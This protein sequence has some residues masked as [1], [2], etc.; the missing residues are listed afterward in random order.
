VCHYLHNNKQHLSS[1]TQPTTEFVQLPFNLLFIHRSV[2][3]RA[4]QGHSAD[5]WY[6]HTQNPVFN[7]HKLATVFL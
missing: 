6:N 2:I 4:L 1:Q 7:L 3:S 5:V